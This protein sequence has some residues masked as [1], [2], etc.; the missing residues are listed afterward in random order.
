MK[1]SVLNLILVGIILSFLCVL[2]INP[3]LCKKGTING[4]LLCGRVII[5]SLFPFTM[6]VIFILNSNVFNKFEKLSPFIKF[7]TGLPFFHFTVLLFSM[8][9]GYP[10]GA[11]LLNNAVENGTIKQKTA[12][13]MLLFCVNAGP[14]FIVSAVG[15]GMLNSQGAGI[16][17]LSSHIVSSIILLLFSRFTTRFDDEIS[18]SFEHEIHPA[19]NFVNSAATASKSVLNICS[20]VLLFSA[21]NEYLN[22]YCSQNPILRFIGS[23]LEVTNGVMLTK[24]VYLISF[25]LGFGGVSVWCQV[26]F[27]AK[28]I[29]INLPKF[30]L[31]RIIHGILS[32]GITF[33]LF[34]LLPQSL[35]TLSNNNFLGFGNFYS[36]AAIGASML[37]M[38]T[39][40]IISISSK[41][42]VDKPFKDMI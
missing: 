31:A 41:K 7:L 39:V 34:K 30:A 22:F 42:Y 21:I 17:L 33:I 37:I 40:L 6:C 38:V 13:K 14:A 25:L 28:N 24:N 19:D 20:F 26:L 11:N 5:P 9:G 10:V 16:I 4:I 35:P 1:K 2:I 3:V 23:L 32:V 15:S 36:T 27:S 8:I 18:Y 12:E 29:K